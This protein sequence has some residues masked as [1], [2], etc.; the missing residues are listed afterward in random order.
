MVY[1]DLRRGSPWSTIE[2]ILSSF[3]RQHH[4]FTQDSFGDFA[5][6]HYCGFKTDILALVSFLWANGST[7]LDERNKRIG[8]TPPTWVTQPNFPYQHRHAHQ[9][10][11]FSWALQ[12]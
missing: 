6:D 7:A 3:W 9:E 5:G 12:F 4:P 11:R 8:W 1:E 2:R 10:H